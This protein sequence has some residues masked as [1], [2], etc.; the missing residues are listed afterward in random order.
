MSL[1]G[2]LTVNGEP[3][4]GAY[5][6]RGIEGLRVAH[7][8]GMNVVLGDHTFLDT[9][10]EE[11]RY[12]LANDIKVMYHLTRQ[13]YWRPRLGQAITPGQTTIPLRRERFKPP[14]ESGLV[15]IDDELI[16]YESW[17]DSA[18]VGC[19]RG[20]DG[21]TASAHRAGVILFWPEECAAEVEHVRESPNLWGYYTL[22]DSPGDAL[23]A[24][25]GMYRTAKRLD[26]DQPVIAGFGS[27]GS[28]TNFDTGVCDAM[29]I[30]WYPVSDNGYDSTMT[31][32]QVQWML[33][34]ARRRVPGIPFV[35][36]Y[37]TFNGG[38]RVEAV[39]TPGQ[40]REQIEDFVREGASGLVSFCMCD[41]MENFPGLA[42]EPELQDVVAAVHR[43]IRST[44][45][46]AFRPE[47]EW[48][49]S[50]RV[51][52]VGQWETPREI[53]GVVPAWYLLGPFDEDAVPQVSAGVV[54]DEEG[55]TYEGKYGPVSWT[56]HRTIGG[57][58]GLGE[59]HGGGHVPRITTLA[60]A[61]VVSPRT[62]TVLALIGSDDDGVLSLNG[63]EVYSFEGSRGLQRDDDTVAVTLPEGPTELALEVHNRGGMSGFFLRFAQL[64][65]APLTGLTFSP[66]GQ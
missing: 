15:Q 43:E 9:T 2:G 17:N 13:V 50:A 47:P 53:P 20:Y 60:R 57:V 4:L 37:Q 35:G 7:D 66:E 23:S 30:Y 29:L 44:G 28:L 24:L 61:T 25:R 14:P 65:G 21:T 39:P 40:V 46:L 52:P 51:Q 11:G 41:G 38:S 19:Q 33:G 1:E 27:A 10:T 42:A 34:E 18:L 56:D 49:R 62:Q 58:I 55:V 31:S 16:H 3:I 6:V 12:C 54:S 5:A 64:D 36:V 8:T 32:H 26:P 22:D 45:A 59:I 63:T 48:M